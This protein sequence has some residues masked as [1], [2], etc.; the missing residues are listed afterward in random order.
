MELL[1]DRYCSISACMPRNIDDRK[2]EY[3]RVYKSNMVQL[4]C[5]GKLTIWSV[6][7]VEVLRKESSVEY[8]EEFHED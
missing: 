2:E 6:Y 4:H 5:S 8:T 7:L 1:S 3:I